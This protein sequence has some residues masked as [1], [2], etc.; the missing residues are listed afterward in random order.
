MV[1]SVLNL[2]DR[3]VSLLLNIYNWHA[4]KWL[5]ASEITRDKQSIQQIIPLLKCEFVYCEEKQVM[6]ITN[7]R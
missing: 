3:S 4:R 2:F 1:G 6:Y 7:Y 5:S